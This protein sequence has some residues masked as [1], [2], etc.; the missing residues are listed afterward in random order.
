M[1]KDIKTFEEAQN[2]TQPVIYVGVDRQE[3]KGFHKV[4]LI[5]ENEDGLQTS[6]NHQ[7]GEVSIQMT[8]GVLKV[9]VRS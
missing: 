6:E 5:H 1:S 3:A 2:T 7:S 9:F 4:V 8:N